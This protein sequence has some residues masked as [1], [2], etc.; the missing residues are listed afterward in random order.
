MNKKMNSQMVAFTLSVLFLMIP[1][2][3][4]S[5]EWKGGSLQCSQTGDY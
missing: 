2:S 3:F 4:D 5:G 1:F